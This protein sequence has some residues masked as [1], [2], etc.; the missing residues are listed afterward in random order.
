[1]AKS[2]VYVE[3][4]VVSYL[5]ARTS[6]DLIVTAHQKATQ[7]WWSE[8]REEFE[9]WVSE[10]VMGE[11]QGGHPEAAQRRIAALVGIPLLEKPRPP[12][13]CWRQR[14]WSVAR[15]Q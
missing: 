15:F 5:T 12:S 2:I 9:L 14:F 6:G 13:N 7:D 3:T 8:R 10:F 4:S 11:A 1:M